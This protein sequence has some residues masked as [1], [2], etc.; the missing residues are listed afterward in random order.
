MTKINDFPIKGAHVIVDSAVSYWRSPIMEGTS[1]DVFRRGTVLLPIVEFAVSGGHGAIR[2]VFRDENRTAVGDSI[3]REIQGRGRIKVASTAGFE[4]M[5]MYAAY[6]TG[7]KKPWTSEVI[8][9]PSPD[10]SST[11]F[12][13]LFEM[14]LSTATR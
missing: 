6:R 4:D 11:E 3:I 9:G 2:V 13:K 1:P 7:G 14:N 12:K 5:G 8:E 10:A